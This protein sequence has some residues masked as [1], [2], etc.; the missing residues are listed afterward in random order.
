[1]KPMEP[2]IQPTKT[3]V[4]A[5]NLA[6][7]GKTA[8]SD[9]LTGQLKSFKLFRLFFCILA[10]VA[11]GLLGLTQPAGK[12]AAD[13]PS[14]D[15]A[16][17]P[18]RGAAGDY[19]ADVVIGQPDFGTIAPNATVPNKLLQPKGALVLDSTHTNGN[20]SK[21]FVYDAGNNRILGVDVASCMATPGPN[22]TADFVIGQPNMNT[23][24]C[25][26]DSGFQRFPFRMNADADTLCTQPEYVFSASETSSGTSM[27]LDNKG[28]LFVADF[29]NHRVLRYPN[30]FLNTPTPIGTI[31]VNTSTPIRANLVI[32]QATS[33]GNSCNR[34]LPFTRPELDSQGNVVRPAAAIP[35]PYANTLC[36]AWGDNGGGFENNNNVAGIDLDAE[37]NLWVVDSG[38]NRVLRF[39]RT[40]QPGTTPDT[41]SPDADRVLGQT[42]FSNRV[43]GN[44]PADLSNPSVVRVDKQTGLVY[45]IDQGYIDTRTPLPTYIPTN[46]PRNLYHRVLVFG[47]TIY[48]VRTATPT[49][50]GPTYTPTPTPTGTFFSPTPT[51]TPTSLNVGTVLRYFHRPWGLDFD[52]NRPDHLWVNGNLDSM[53]Q[54]WRIPTGTPG[55]ATPTLMQILQDLSNP[56][57]SIGLDPSDPQTERVF[58]NTESEANVNAAVHDVAVFELPKSPVPLPGTPVAQ[59]KALFGYGGSHWGNLKNNAELAEGYGVAVSNNPARSQLFVSDGDRVLFWNNPTTSSGVLDLTNGQVAYSTLYQPPGSAPDNYLS[60]KATRSHLYVCINRS[61]APNA[62]H[63]RI[64]IYQLPVEPT[65]TPVAR[66]RYPEDFIT[67]EGQHLEHNYN[68]RE[69]VLF[70]APTSD[71]RFL[72][73]GISD[74]SRI[75]RVRNPLSGGNDRQVDMILGQTDAYNDGCNCHKVTNWASPTFVATP[76][77]SDNSIVKT[78]GTPDVFDAGARSVATIQP[79]DNFWM[80][81]K[82]YAQM[83]VGGAGTPT[84]TPYPLLAFG[85]RSDY[86]ATP[87]PTGTP[88][89]DYRKIDFAFR[90]NPDGTLSIY[91]RGV[92]VSLSVTPTYTPGTRLRVSLETN[93]NQT[94]VATRRYD[95]VYYVNDQVVYAHDSRYNN[96]EYVPV[97]FPLYFEGAIATIGGRVNNAYL[98][99]S[100]GQNVTEDSL[101]VPSFTTIDRKGN[102]WV[103]DHSLEAQGN[104]RLLEFDANQFPTTTSTPTQVTSGV[105]ARRIY[106]DIGVWE[107]AF[108]HENRL[109]ISYNH[110]AGPNNPHPPTPIFTPLPGT[111]TVAPEFLNR[112]IGLFPGM[113]ANPLAVPVLPTY[114]PTRVPTSMPSPTPT[115][116]IPA[117]T[118]DALLADL[119]SMGY[120]ATFDDFDNLYIRDINRARVMIYKQPGSGTPVIWDPVTMANV[121]ITPTSNSIEKTGGNNGVW[122]AGAASLQSF[123]AGSGYVQMTANQTNTDRAF[124]LRG[125]TTTPT[126]GIEGIDYGFALLHDNGTPSIHVYERGVAVQTFTPIP[127]SAND[128]LKVAVEES[129]GINSAPTPTRVVNYYYNGDKVYSNP[130]AVPT[131]A[132]P[133]RFDASIASVNGQVNN[134]FITGNLIT[135]TPG[136]FCSAGWCTTLSPNSGNGSNVFNGVA[137]IDA[138]NIWAVGG[139]DVTGQG[140]KSLVEYWHNGTWQVVGSDDVGVLHGISAVDSNHIWSVGDRDI[141]FYNG[142]SWSSANTH[143]GGNGVYALSANNVWVVGD[144]STGNGV[145]YFDGSSWSVEPATSGGILNAVAASASGSAWTVGYTGTA[146]N[147]SPRIL[148]RTCSTGTSCTWNAATNPNLNTDAFLN[149]INIYDSSHMW[150]VGSYYFNPQ[151]VPSSYRTLTEY[152]NGSAWSVVPSPNHATTEG[153]RNELKSVWFGKEGDVWSAGE[154]SAFS[155]D[156]FATQR[157]LLHWNDTYWEEVLAPHPGLSSSF[158]AV[159]SETGSSAVITHTWAV[160][161]YKPYYGAS[162]QT[163]AERIQAPPAPYTTTSYYENSI[164]Y[165]THYSQGYDAGQN[166]ESGIVVLNYGQPTHW[167]NSQGH[168]VY[169]TSLIGTHA[170]APIS[171]PDNDIPTILG[172]VESF[173]A[174]YA[175]GATNE[176]QAITITISLNNN[177]TTGTN[178]LTGA[179][180]GAWAQM[181][182]DVITY[183]AKNK[184]ANIDVAAGMDVEPDWSKFS[185][186]Y[187]WLKAY[188]SYPY[189]ICYNIGGTDGYPLLPAG[190]PTPVVPPPWTSYSPWDTNQ[191]YIASWGIKGMRAMP[192]ISHPQWSRDWYRVKRWSNVESSPTQVPMEF[193]GTISEYKC[194]SSHCQQQTGL[195]FDPEQAWQTFWLELNADPDTRIQQQLQL[196]SN[197]KCSNDTGNVDC[198][199]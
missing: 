67:V 38:N 91:E 83:T 74:D 148:Y 112:F 35:T 197:I 75:L 167:T 86:N 194:R 33:S 89:H 153:S 138:N 10:L 180:A 15:N 141:L 95:I 184:W 87:T 27:A 57:G 105:A 77:D 187:D 183:V 80:P 88:F 123:R 175:A 84:G 132:F 21:L 90:L 45:V 78:A 173:A 92:P 174:G 116:T 107:P 18:P 102:V 182:K 31:A 48:P 168:T 134:A 188:N 66:L 155:S 65:S 143:V 195:T 3:N 185:E 164:D 159:A 115:D 72:W 122:D 68:D 40:P 42:D 165:G 44:G 79:V 24:G 126:A 154:Y 82:G 73:V 169:G 36:F 118:P 189:S 99:A 28:Q 53:L 198:K 147:R 94:S 199:P 156:P 20:G 97:H 52:P 142:S 104:I 85:L 158:S 191:L 151:N 43:Y 130:I 47:P 193:M 5:N 149:G 192:S 63:S 157:F 101:C 127:Y 144:N 2:Q 124:G 150:A 29:Y 13:A 108:D 7:Y 11:V 121:T 113:Y 17:S 196:S 54:A 120:A 64:D 6:E 145:R 103:T 81:V 14:D 1:M 172:A 30:L 190:T 51:S 136:V 163:L 114:S 160:G 55:T 93:D 177:N 162:S 25:N 110:Y 34:V 171:D 133:M 146:P 62:S 117:P 152:W 16:A 12:V 22:C 8:I 49:P 100:E 111:P 37:G 139:Y 161:S 19:W 181:V 39:P 9:N 178:E 56:V 71:D 179:H 96:N 60:L 125:P 59:T 131:T 50:T 61:N 70:A 26:R 98:A 76:V 166:V 129:Y 140:G 23:A 135:P 137:V 46:V 32:G 186:A 69:A 4:A 128:V 106:N 41:F 176:H 109:F 170:L 58:V 119:Y